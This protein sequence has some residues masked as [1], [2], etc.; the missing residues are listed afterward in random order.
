[1]PR[2][3]G[4]LNKATIEKQ[5]RDDELIA[6]VAHQD[7][8]SNILSGL[9]SAADK[10]IHTTKDVFELI[11]DE[12]LT[13][14]YMSEGLGRRIVDIIADDETREWIY[15]DE[16]KYPAATI[17]TINDELTRLSA[18]STYNEALKWQRLY[19][20]SLI[21]I[22]AMD[23]RVPSEPLRENQ[24]KNIEFLRVIDRTDVDISG[25]KYDYNE[26][27]PT[28]GKIL[29]YK[30]NIHVGDRYI[31]SLIHHS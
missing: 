9:G 15:F 24:I 5:K 1:M 13:D 31:E 28:F 7:G 16:S 29:Q 27:S 12:T 30:V 18:E 6:Q 10:S 19:G 11:D 26:K 2:P 25:S 17:K 22:G 4:S 14:I 20:G 8:W 21:F 23:G 3:K